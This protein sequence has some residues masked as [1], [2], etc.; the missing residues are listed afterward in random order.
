MAVAALMPAD[1]R[2][3]SPG[4]GKGYDVNMMSRYKINWQRLAFLLPLSCSTDRGEIGSVCRERY[5]IA[6]GFDSVTAL[7]NRF[8]IYS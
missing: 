4:L 7:S 1:H 2:W 6:R 3:V 8:N 5:L